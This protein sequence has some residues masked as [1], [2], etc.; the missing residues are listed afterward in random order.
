MISLTGWVAAF[1]PMIGGQRFQTTAQPVPNPCPL[2]LPTPS[3][4]R[5]RTDGDGSDFI[6]NN[7]QDNALPTV[8]I[9]PAR[10]LPNPFP[11]HAQSVPAQVGSVAVRLAS[12]DGKRLRFIVDVSR[13]APRN[14]EDAAEQFVELM[15]DAVSCGYLPATVPFSALRKFYG[16]IASKFEWQEISDV[17]LS[18]LLEANGCAK[19]VKRDRS[20]GKDKRTVAYRLR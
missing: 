15:R 1:V 4:S 18:K 7:A 6:E 9:T 5:H 19:T 17:R 2:S 3:R 8:A 12:C 10:P 14:F 20:G 13:P 16:A 11:T